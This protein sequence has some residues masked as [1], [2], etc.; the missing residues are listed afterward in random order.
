MLMNSTDKGKEK[1]PKKR[2]S[3]VAA[4]N[5]PS[6]TFEQLGIEMHSGLPVFRVKIL[7]AN[8][9]CVSD[10]IVGF[11]CPG[12]GGEHSHGW[13]LDMDLAK[14]SHRGSHC[15]SGL[16]KGN[17]YYILPDEEMR[18]TIERDRRLIAENPAKYKKLCPRRHKQLAAE[19]SAGSETSM[20]NNAAR[21]EHVAS[22][23][24]PRVMINAD[25]AA[26]T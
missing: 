5:R 9:T 6:P 20:S 17:G 16:L 7:P 11:D 13:E 8:T 15:C 19:L 26:D 4:A 10:Y 3:T 21:F 24:R 12:C 2:K 18:Q 14:P 25:S 1:M 23:S 22:I